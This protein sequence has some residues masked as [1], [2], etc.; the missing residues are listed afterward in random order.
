MLLAIQP[1]AIGDFILSLPALRA[2]REALG[3]GG[4]EIWAERANLPLAEHPAY[5]DCVR[6]LAETGLDSYPL[7]GRTLEALKEFDT[8][9]S[10]R[11]ASLPELV[12]AVRAVQ[13]GACFLPQF[14]PAGEAIHLSEFRR[15]QLAALLGDHLVP[16][17]LRDPQIFL[18]ESDTRFAEEFLGEWCGPGGPV[19]VFHAGASGKR[20]QWD[21]AR[22]GALALQAQRRRDARI[23]LTEGPLDAEAVGAVLASAP[24]L[25]ARRV[26]IP[27]LRQLAAVISRAA[28]FLGNDTGIA[29][30]AAAAS[31]PAIVVFMAGDPRVWAPRGAHVR[32]LVNPSLDE[33]AE[34]I[35]QVLG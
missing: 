25:R 12:A 11:G 22:F 29:H 19:M 15:K 8:I 2:L 24:D 28:V 32:I 9:V 33:A 7:P 13:P 23:L 6:P 1:G 17:R 30:L 18:S 31:V 10:W 20:K 14:P 3:A 21:A 34:E 4:M 35:R 27:N 16:A 5:A 26:C